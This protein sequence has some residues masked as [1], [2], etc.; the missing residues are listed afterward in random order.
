MKWYG[1]P[2]VIDVT[3]HIV[4]MLALWLKFG[5]AVGLGAGSVIITLDQIFWVLCDMNEKM[6]G[7][8]EE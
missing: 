3:A 7:K 1:K 2:N 8:K 5:W 6:K 4:I